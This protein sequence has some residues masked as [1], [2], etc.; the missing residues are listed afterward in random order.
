ME[1][2]DLFLGEA[3]AQIGISWHAL[4]RLRRLGRIPE[5]RRLGRYHVFPREQIP[6]IRERLIQQ[7][8]IKQ[9]PAP[10]AVGA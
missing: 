7:G 6:A 5:A 9:T 8:F 3:A 10:E 1:P 2:T 4:A